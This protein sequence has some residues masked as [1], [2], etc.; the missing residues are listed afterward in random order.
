MAK[1]NTCWD[2]ACAIWDETAKYLLYRFRAYTPHAG[3]V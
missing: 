3:A 2:I 1:Q